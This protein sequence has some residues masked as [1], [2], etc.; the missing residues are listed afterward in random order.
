MH[1]SV[2]GA[3]I[4]LKSDAELLSF[5]SYTDYTVLDK[6]LQVLLASVSSYEKY[7]VE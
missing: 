6:Y 5:S 2:C 3:Q 1:S 7:K 4:N